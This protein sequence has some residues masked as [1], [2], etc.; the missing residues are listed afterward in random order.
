MDYECTVFV[1]EL[2]TQHVVITKDFLC[3]QPGRRIWVKHLLDKVLRSQGDLG[4]WLLLEIDP[5]LD[6]RLCNSFICVCTLVEHKRPLAQ[7]K[8]VTL[9][10]SV[11][12]G[13]Q[14]C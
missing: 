3:R 4:P 14:S 7:E 11:E 6:Y 13:N 12:T 9:E 8:P 2:E 1:C 5:T 10:V